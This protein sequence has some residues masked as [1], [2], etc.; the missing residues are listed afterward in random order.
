MLL[1]IPNGIE[2]SEHPKKHV[3]VVVVVNFE[4]RLMHM[5]MGA[6][7]VNFPECA[8]RSVLSATDDLCTR[9]RRNAIHH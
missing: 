9:L 2:R 4:T 3:C 7:F 1:V 8:F 5:S 6:S